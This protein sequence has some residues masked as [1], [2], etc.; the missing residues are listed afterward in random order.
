VSNPDQI[1]NKLIEV[2]KKRA[3]TDK[4]M[5]EARGRHAKKSDAAAS[6]RSRAARASSAATA[7]SHLRSADLAERAALAEGRKIAEYSKRSAQ[8]SKQ[9]AVLD[10]ELAFALRRQAAREQAARKRQD[11][12][13]RRAREWERGA[14]RRQADPLGSAVEDRLSGQI[15]EIRPPKVERLRILYLTAASEGDLRVDK[16]IRRVKA[17]VQAATHRDLVQLEHM[18]AATASDLLDGLA[19]FRPQVVHF[20][21]HAGPDVLAFDTDADT[22]DSGHLV[23]AT[24]FAKAIGSVDEPPTLVVLN[25]CKSAGQLAGLLA[26]VPIAIGM[27]DSVGDPDAMAFA[28]RFYTAIAEGQSIYSAWALATVQMEFDGLPH[29]DLPV[30]EFRPEVDPAKVLL[31]IPAA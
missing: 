31:V 11:E 30:L 22:N 25:A 1:R 29:A 21:G 26:V 6:Y 13:D 15:A 3:E 24:A 14:E 16:E 18:P 12:A 28:A 19:R 17:G 7:R 8:Y 5:A 9:V 10:K 27:A 2:G 20:S 4:R 23:T